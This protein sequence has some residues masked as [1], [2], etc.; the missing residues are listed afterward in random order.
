MTMFDM[1][2][3]PERDGNGSRS[4]LPGHASPAGGATDA[5]R[6]M[7]RPVTTSLASRNDGKTRAC[8]ALKFA[9]AGKRGVAAWR[10]VVPATAV[11]ARS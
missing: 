6:V 8:G 11:T 9:A 2:R 1:K 7:P 5:R 3:S 10:R 4:G